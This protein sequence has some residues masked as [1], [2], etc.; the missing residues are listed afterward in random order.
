MA[1]AADASRIQF[2]TLN[3]R[4]GPAVRATR[5]QC[6]RNLYRAFIRKTVEQQANLTVFQAAVDDLL[7]DGCGVGGC[8][9]SND[10]EFHSTTVVRRSCR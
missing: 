5:A 4:K 10:L 1:K 2:P 9:T 3:S 8:R 6:D 7:S